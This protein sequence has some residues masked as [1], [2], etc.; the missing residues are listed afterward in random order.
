MQTLKTQK[1]GKQLLTSNFH[2]MKR[3]ALLF[4][5]VLTVTFTSSCSSDDDSSLNSGDIIGNW[6]L[7]NY[8]DPWINDIEELEDL[9]P[10]ESLQKRAFSSE[11]ITTLTYYYGNNCQYQGTRNDQF[12]I[13]GNV[14]TITEPNGGYNPNTD[15][16]V[17]YNIRTL[18]ATT[19]VLEGF[20]V[21]EGDGYNPNIPQNERFTETWTRIE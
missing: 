7:T 4:L 1:Q 6:K 17:K 11:N 5:T 20:Y 14:L 21:D 9:E 8:N 2:F 13:S 19:L 18:N 15:Y 3:V 12:S 16:V 10:C